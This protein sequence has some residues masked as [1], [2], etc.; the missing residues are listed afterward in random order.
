MKQNQLNIGSTSQLSFLGNTSYND[1]NGP[2]QSSGAINSFRT[3]FN[4]SCDQPTLKEPFQHCSPI[5]HVPKT[6]RIDPNIKS[7][8]TGPFISTR[9]Q[10]RKDKR[11]HIMTK[12]TNK[13]PPINKF[14]N[15][16]ILAI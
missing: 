14:E 13:L 6:S 12:K 9:E 15:I 7:F 4:L 3:N 11:I 8:P 16:G 10:V 2:Q 1:L 5:L